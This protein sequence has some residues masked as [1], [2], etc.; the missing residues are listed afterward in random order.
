LQYLGDVYN[1][2][3]RWDEA[4]TVYKAALEL[5]AK[6][7]TLMSSLGDTLNNAKR[8][9]EAIQIFKQALELQPDSET[10]LVG[11]LQSR[12][13]IAQWNGLKNLQRKLVALTRTTLDRHEQQHEQAG[14][15]AKMTP[16]ALQP[17]TALFVRG[18][19]RQLQ[20]RI[21]S[22]WAST[23]IRAA[24]VANQYQAPLYLNV[25]TTN[26][27]IDDN[28][29]EAQQGARLLRVG[30]ISRRF[31]SYPGTRLMLRM[32]SLHDRSRFKV[33]AYAH[34]PDDG[35][36]ERQIV[37]RDCN[38]FRDVS[39]LSTGQVARVIADDALDVLISCMY[40]LSLS[41]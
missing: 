34:G 12:L 35:S 5:R 27:V 6:D 41:L 1:N 20:R 2:L 39:Q 29:L 37:Q 28:D 13:E 30:Y 8:H 17:Y 40:S 16:V 10:L 22:S 4:I 21:S 18:V 7:V 15:N 38:V 32:F 9:S 11:L 33:Y 23:S 31:E 19:D 24:R 25:S 3:K 26:G 14:A 36:L